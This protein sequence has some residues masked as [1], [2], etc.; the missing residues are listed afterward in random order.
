MTIIDK[1]TRQVNQL[2][3]ITILQRNQAFKDIGI[4]GTQHGYILN[5]CREPGI[6]Q[7]QLAKKLYVNKSNV[8][9]QVAQLVEGGFI[10][11]HQSETDKRAVMLQPTQKAKDIY[12]IIMETLNQWNLFLVQELS[13]DQRQQLSDILA[14]VVKRA[15][16]YIG[17]REQDE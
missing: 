16:D 5:V 9:R 17:E 12:P 11:R 4:T 2:A 15:A 10:T 3:R 14:Q 8:A 13:L 7:D 6:T 1:L